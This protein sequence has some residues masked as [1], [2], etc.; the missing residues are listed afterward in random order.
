MTGNLFDS[1]EPSPPGAADGWLT[2]HCDGGSR[3]NPGP[4]GYGA[5][6]EDAQGRV[7]ARL[8]EFLGRQT[9]NYAEYSGLL[10][11][12]KWAT[13]MVRSACALSPTRS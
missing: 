13:R 8:N 12:L 5:V 2:A 4:S 10:A 6:I 7:V 3:G 9:N 11:A 1:A